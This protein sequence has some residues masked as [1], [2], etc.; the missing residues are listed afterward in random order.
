MKPNCR[1][2]N[3]IIVISFTGSCHRDILCSLWRQFRQHH[4]IS[5]A[6]MLLNNMQPEHI[7]NVTATQ[8]AK[9]MGPTWGPPGSCRPQMSPMLAPWTLL[10]C[11]I[12]RKYPKEDAE[13]LVVAFVAI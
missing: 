8:I 7:R 6:C 11:F 12:I 3:D 5:V 2:I 13:V 10:S 1:H 9:F 4:D